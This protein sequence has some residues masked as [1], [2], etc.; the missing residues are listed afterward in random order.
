[1]HLFGPV[2]KLS[3]FNVLALSSSPNGLV[4]F[5]HYSSPLARF[6]RRDARTA[7][8]GEGACLLL[9]AD[10]SHLP[11]RGKLGWMT[12]RVGVKTTSASGTRLRGSRS[13]AGAP[14]FC[15]LT[16]QTATHLACAALPQLNSRTHATFLI[17]MA[18]E[19]RSLTFRGLI[20]S[21]RDRDAGLAERVRH[22]R[23]PQPRSVIFKRHLLIL[24]VHP[25]SP[26]SIGVGELS[27]AAQLL[28]AHRRLQF[29]GDFHECH[30][31][32]I[33]AST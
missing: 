14:F 21:A 12:P 13:Q 32:I 10:R 3:V 2:H 30:A 4:P 29:V 26:Q 15:A 24:V 25:E 27:Q 16:K 6:S 23:F 33:P 22:L 11:L 19:F 1:M 9:L 28:Q 18:G 5:V 20:H 8:E 7:S 17:V 31:R